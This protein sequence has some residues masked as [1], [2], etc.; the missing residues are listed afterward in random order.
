MCDNRNKHIPVAYTECAETTHINDFIL[1]SS[2]TADDDVSLGVRF[3]TQE[4]P[5]RTRLQRR[6]ALESTREITRT[7]CHVQIKKEIHS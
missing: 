4:Q 1:L 3:Q 5:T 2:A 6:L 7:F